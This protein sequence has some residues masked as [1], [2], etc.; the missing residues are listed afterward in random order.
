MFEGVLELCSSAL[1]A[2]P[3]ALTDSSFIFESGRILTQE[4]THSA[5]ELVFMFQKC[6]GYCCHAKITVIEKR[7]GEKL[8]C[9]SNM[10]S[11]VCLTALVDS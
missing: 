5:Q 10:V 9:F 1:S 6:S 2:L 7:F 11:V 4:K 3:N 8:P